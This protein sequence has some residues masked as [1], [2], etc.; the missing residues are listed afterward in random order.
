MC[1]EACEGRRRRKLVCKRKRRPW[2]QQCGVWSGLAADLVPRSFSCFTV[3]YG[4]RERGHEERSGAGMQG[5]ILLR[6][7]VMGEKR[8]GEEGRAD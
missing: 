8:K 7:K 5:L 6:E 4:G 3:R 1:G 2:L